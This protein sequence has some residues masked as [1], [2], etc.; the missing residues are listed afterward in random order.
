MSGFEM[1]IANG[2]TFEKYANLK[3]MEEGSCKGILKIEFLKHVYRLVSIMPVIQ[4]K[5]LLPYSTKNVFPLFS[6]S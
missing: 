5:F 2:I 1:V 6:Y 3:K 4:M